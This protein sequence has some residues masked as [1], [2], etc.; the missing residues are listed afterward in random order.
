MERGLKMLTCEKCE[1]TYT[2]DLRFY[3]MYDTNGTEVV[4]CELCREDIEDEWPKK[5]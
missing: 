2:R 5:G 1:E 4:V 3:R